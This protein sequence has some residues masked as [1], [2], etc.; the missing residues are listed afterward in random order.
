MRSSEALEPYEFNIHCF[1]VLA[2]YNF[3]HL[4]HS[5]QIDNIEW[6]VSV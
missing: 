2:L 6:L 3:N 5:A 1:E 4:S